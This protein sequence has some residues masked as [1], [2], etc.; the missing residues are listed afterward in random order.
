MTTPGSP[1]AATAVAKT[2]GAAT[3]ENRFLLSSVA[4]LRAKQLQCGARPHVEPE[5]HKPTHIALLEVLADTISWS[6]EDPPVVNKA[7]V[8]A[9]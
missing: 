7:V 1:G 6:V 5:R 4:F 3:L 9:L 2:A 8:A